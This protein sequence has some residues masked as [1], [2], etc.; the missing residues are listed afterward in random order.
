MTHPTVSGFLLSVGLGSGLLLSLGFQ[1]LGSFCSLLFFLAPWALPTFLN[2]LAFPNSS[3][4]L[5]SGSVSEAFL[6]GFSRLSHFCLYPFKPLLIMSL[7]W[8]WLYPDLRSLKMNFS[9]ISNFSWCSRSA[10]V[11]CDLQ[12]TSW[13]KVALFEFQEDALHSRVHRDDEVLFSQN[14]Y[15]IW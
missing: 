9:M 13:L 14:L 7:T 15:L 2:K 4:L 8:S 10:E 11:L 6:W 5:L 1:T 12:I 3:L